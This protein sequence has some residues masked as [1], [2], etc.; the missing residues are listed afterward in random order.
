M[1][2]AERHV[3]GIEIRAVQSPDE[4]R[5]VQLLQQR[6]WES[7]NIDL[8]PAH[9]LITITKNGGVLLGA[10]ALDG[11]SKTAGMV[12][13]VLGWPGYGTDN[14]GRTAPKHCSLMI[15]VIPEYRRRGIGLALKFAQRETVLAQ[16]ITEWVTWTFDPMQRINAI[17]NL[18]RLGA[19]STTYLLDAYGKLDDAINFGLPT[20][21]LQVDWRLRSPRVLTAT[22]A[23]QTAH[24]WQPE[25]LQILTAPDK[26][27]VDHSNLLGLKLQ[28]T[29]PL[30][31]PIPHTINPVE[32]TSPL[33]WQ[34]F[35]RKVLPTA[36]ECGYHL[37]NCVCLPEAGWHYILTPC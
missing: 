22:S 25:E 13:F 24:I 26:R 14:S 5:H 4:C 3:D 17:F 35:L 30:A 20:D 2:K 23:G 15:A 34:H 6:V 27:A 29:I 18:N 36:F 7:G 16:G 37:T 33:Q 12:G 19:I 10:F 32:G 8:V 21:R 28:K 1:N 31:I 9:M 11:P